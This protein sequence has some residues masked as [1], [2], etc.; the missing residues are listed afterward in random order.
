MR[1]RYSAGIF[2][3]GFLCA[4]LGFQIAPAAAPLA[5]FGA[6]DMPFNCEVLLRIKNVLLRVSYF[7]SQFQPVSFWLAFV[8][9]A[10]QYRPD[11][12]SARPFNNR[13]APERYN[14]L[15]LSRNGCVLSKTSE[16]FFSRP[17][18]VRRLNAFYFCGALLMNSRTSAFS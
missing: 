15:Y 18:R 5:Y 12:F 14:H 2:D 1:G 6:G 4:G 13:R 8:A 7:S 3:G 11:I 9:S 16:S 17:R 10:A